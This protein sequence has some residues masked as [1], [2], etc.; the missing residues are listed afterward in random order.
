MALAP[1]LD[2]LSVP[3][4]SFSSASIE[5][6]VA[7][8]E[9]LDRRAEH[10][11]HGVDGLQ[12]ALAEVAVLVAVAQLVGLERTGGCAGGDGGAGDGA[13]VEQHLDLDGRVAP[14]VEDFAGADSFDE[15]HSELLCD[16]GVRWTTPS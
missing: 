4:A 11:E 3:S 10:V 15:C 6:L 1:R 9:A 12:H 7:G 5:A 2:L 16:G 8:V 13:V 14:G